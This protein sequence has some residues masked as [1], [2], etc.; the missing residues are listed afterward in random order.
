MAKRAGF[1]LIELMIVVAIISV[2]AAIAIPNLIRAK[3]SAHEASAMSGMRTIPTAE[4]A[5]QAAAIEATANGRGNY[6]TLLSL[7]IGTA[8]F[9]DESLSGGL[10]SGYSYEAIPGPASEA[11]TYTATAVPISQGSTGIRAFFVNES[12]VIRF[13]S[14]GATNPSVTSPP[15]N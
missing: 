6:G 4:V 1:T 11:P 9:V 3:I 12:D 15:L 10:R 14:D 2:L 13:E 5:Y 7:G 8:P